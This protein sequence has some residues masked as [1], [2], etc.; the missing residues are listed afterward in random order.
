M[1]LLI[2]LLF[3]T[4]CNL[5]IVHAQPLV[6]FMPVK[7]DSVQLSIIKKAIKDNY[8]KDSASITGENKKQIVQL[9][10]ER[11]EFI[12]EMFVDKE[13]IYTAETNNYLTLLVNEIFKHNPQLK[14][15]GTRFLFSRAYWPN[16]FST[17]EG[18]IVFNIGLF[19][20]LDNESQVVFAL[21]H[22]LSHLYLKHSNK[23][24]EHYI[25]TVYSDEFQKQLKTLKKQQYERNKELDKLEK[26]VVYSSRRHGREHEAEADSMALVF[27]KNTGFDVAESLACLKILD[28]ID[29]GTYNTEEGLPLLFNLPDYPFQNKWIKKEAAFFDI[30]ADNKITDKEEDSLK[31]HPDCKLRITKLTPLVEKIKTNTAKKF[32]VD[33]AGFIKLKQLFT[34]EIIAFCYNSK[35]ISRCLYQAMELYKQYPDN[36]Y[37]TT[38]I[39]KCFNLMYTNQKAHTLNK[40]VSL[41]SPIGEKNYNTLL[42]FIQNISLKDIGAIGYF[43]L[44]QHEAQFTT[45]KEFTA[46]FTQGKTNINS[47]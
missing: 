30:S 33:E 47:Y 11:F 38:M 8:L 12:N 6:S 20:K 27:M 45:D 19:T 24:L 28:N 39:G 10:R 22:E 4:L 17:G 42:E 35:R 5:F 44:K 14:S 46:T 18:T 13:F 21:C 16:A 7:D 32:V 36:A 43:F 26:T 25:N 41:P 29:K 2:C 23:A 1:R 40:I 37:I 15:P 3:T 9:Y 31:T 34:F